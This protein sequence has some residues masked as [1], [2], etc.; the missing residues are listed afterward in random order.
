M[1]AV[2]NPSIIYSI[3]YWPLVSRVP[4]Q[5]QTQ[6]TAVVQGYNIYYWK[7]STIRLT[8]QFKPVLFKG[9]LYILIELSWGSVL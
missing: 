2:K 4:P 8:V 7:E 3:I 1:H 6:P 9:Q 5:P